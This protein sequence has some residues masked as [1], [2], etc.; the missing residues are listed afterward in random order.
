M[1][2]SKRNKK[3]AAAKA[4]KLKQGKPATSRYASK[5]VGYDYSTLYRDKR[6]SWRDR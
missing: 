4:A 5:G 3:R 6:L 1:K 2:L